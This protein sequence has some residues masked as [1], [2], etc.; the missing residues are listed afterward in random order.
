MPGMITLYIAIGGFSLWF[1]F[2]ICQVLYSVW[3]WADD[4]KQKSLW[5]KSEGK[6]IGVGEGIGMAGGM[7][8]CLFMIIMAW[9]IVIPGG[10]ITGFLF[11]CAFG[12]RKIIRFKKKVDKAIKKCKPKRKSKAITHPT[13]KKKKK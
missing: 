3:L 10:F 12:L 9:K 4:A 7:A 11:L 6:E 2:L 8:V 13:I 1:V 5:G